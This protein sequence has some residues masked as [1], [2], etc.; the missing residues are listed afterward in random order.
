MGWVDRAQQ[1]L[2]YGRLLFICHDNGW[3]FCLFDNPIAVIRIKF[4]ENVIGTCI[5]NRILGILF[6]PWYFGKEVSPKRDRNGSKL[7]FKYDC[8]GSMWLLWSVGQT[9]LYTEWPLDSFNSKLKLLGSSLPFATTLIDVITV[10][11]LMLDAKR[12][13]TESNRIDE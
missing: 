9:G 13:L 7:K 3:R 2:L 4:S 5:P 11:P 1:Q 8:F 12:N 10:M 6:Q